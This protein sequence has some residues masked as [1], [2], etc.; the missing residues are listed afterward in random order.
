MVT[1]QNLRCDQATT[2]NASRQGQIMKVLSLKLVLPA[3]ILAIVFFGFALADGTGNAHGLWTHRAYRAPRHPP[4]E[5]RAG[6]LQAKIQYCSDCH[7]PSGQGYR[8]FFPMPRLAGQ[9][10]EYFE[11]QLRAFVERRRENNIAI[12]MSKVH[13]LSPEM[14]TALAAR[15]TALNPKPFGNAPIKLVA[16]GKKIYE[17]GDPDANVP[18]C[19]ACHGPEAKGSGPIPRLAGQLYPYT[20]KEL[21]NWS[22]ERG[23]DA[24][25]PDTSAIM[26]P[27]AHSL[28]ESQIEAVAAYLSYLE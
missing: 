8:G 28:T 14:Q 6:T 27:I 1:G 17:E 4:V 11:N 3:V 23:Q 18:A 25:N 15:F 13:G 20:L 2:L 12:V 19:S 16:T 26:K 5:A 9:T 24:A 21:A 7:G 10:T 22:K